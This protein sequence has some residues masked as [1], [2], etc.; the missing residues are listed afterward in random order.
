MHAK[1]EWDDVFKTL[2]MG[3]GEEESVNQVFY[4][5]QSCMS[6]KKEG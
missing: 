6:E 3:V 4:T 1:R 5:Q 2:K